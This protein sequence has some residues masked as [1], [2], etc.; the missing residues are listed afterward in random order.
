MNPVWHSAMTS[1]LTVSLCQPSVDNHQ[2]VLSSDVSKLPCRRSCL[3]LGLIKTHS[4]FLQKLPQV[5]G[6]TK[7]TGTESTTIGSSIEQLNRVSLQGSQGTDTATI[8][9]EVKKVIV[10][11]LGTL[12]DIKKS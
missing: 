4:P 8:L 2:A 1:W 5:I 11:H 3:P 7:S 12:I 10:P 9:T 6:L